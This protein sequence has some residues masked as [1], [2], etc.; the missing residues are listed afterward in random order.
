[1]LRTPI[2]DQSQRDP[3]YYEMESYCGDLGYSFNLLSSQQSYEKLVERISTPAFQ[4]LWSYFI[5]APRFSYTRYPEFFSHR[6]N[7]ATLV[8]VKQYFNTGA[9]VTFLTEA[10]VSTGRVVCLEW[11]WKQAVIHD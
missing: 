11:E 2:S 3:E 9:K 7:Q 4:R 5:Q 1:M 6:Y 8:I 10:P